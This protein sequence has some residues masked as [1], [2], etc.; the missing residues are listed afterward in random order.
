[1]IM[2]TKINGKEFMINSDL[3]QSLEE[4]P[5]TVITFTNHEKI[6][7]QETIPV[8]VNKIK[9]FKKEIQQWNL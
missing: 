8:I 9:N 4:T 7:V 1:M 2:V 3:I 5:D 6:M